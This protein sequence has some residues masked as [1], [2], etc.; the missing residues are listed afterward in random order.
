[1][2]HNGMINWMGGGMLIWTIVGTLMI[3]SLL[4]AIFTM[5]KK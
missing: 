3:V 2:M 1:M 4:V 5:L